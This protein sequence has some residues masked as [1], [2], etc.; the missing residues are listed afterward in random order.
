MTISKK[1]KILSGL[2]FIAFSIVLFIET[3]NFPLP[4]GRD[5]GSAYW[6][7]ILIFLLIAFSVILIIQAFVSKSPE[8]N[9]PDDERK[10]VNYKPLLGIFSIVLFV[11]FFEILGFVISIFIFY[12]LSN[13]I[14]REKM[15]LKTFGFVVVQAISLMIIIYLLFV[16]LLSVSLPLGIF[17]F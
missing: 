11:V 16:Q 12:I 15:N 9:S 5:I 6:P 14:L 2:V 8:D 7:R 1:H 4:N 17:D 3:Q 10:K 13:L